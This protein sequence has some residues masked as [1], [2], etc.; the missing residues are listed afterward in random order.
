MGHL[1]LQRVGR[2]AGRAACLGTGRKGSKVRLRTPLAGSG[3]A[4]F[5]CM[6]SK[7]STYIHHQL[8]SDVLPGV[9]TMWKTWALHGS[10]QGNSKPGRQRKH[11]TAL[12]VSC[13]RYQLTYSR[14]DKL[15]VG[16]RRRPPS[17]I[18]KAKVNKKACQ[19]WEFAIPVGLYQRSI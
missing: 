6:C 16:N 2:I 14:C 17:K 15:S 9:R 3:R 12:P 1:I 8:N 7:F 5:I 18:M 19:E 4:H 11:A 13:W 10:F